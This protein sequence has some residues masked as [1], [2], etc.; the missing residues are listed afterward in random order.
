METIKEQ[1]YSGVFVL[2]GVNVPG[3]IIH[4]PSKGT[5]K[6][7][8]TRKLEDQETLFALSQVNYR[9]RESIKGKLHTGSPIVLFNCRN[10]TNTLDG[11]AFVH[12][13]RFSADY[14]IFDEI[15]HIGKRYCRYECIIENGLLW[16]DMTQLQTVTAD[17]ILTENHD[18]L[19]VRN[20]YIILFNKAAASKK[21]KWYD[22]EIEF[23]TYLD[24]ADF[25]RYP[26]GES[27]KVIERLKI[28]ITPQTRKNVGHFL[29]IRREI[30]AMI[31]FAI[32]DNVNILQ[33]H[34]YNWDEYHTIPIEDAPPIKEH[35][36]Y[37]MISNERYHTV[38][39]VVPQEY[40]FLLSQLPEGKNFDSNLEK[41][42]PVFHLYL[43]F[44]TYPDMPYEMLFLNMTQ[45]LETFHEQFYNKGISPDI[46]LRERLNELLFFKDTPFA[47]FRDND[48]PYAEILVKTR[49]YYTHYDPSLKNAALK[50][51]DL[52]DAIQVL[53]WLLEY[54]VCKTLRIDIS[55]EVKKKLDKYF[56]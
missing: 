49:N 54:Q 12:T 39:D 45:A 5:I 46:T 34:F 32:K 2:D 47:R 37:G 18:N 55:E 8:L 53:K 7:S 16:S 25:N 51:N 3:V 4:N 24:T 36:L 27:N 19:D 14:M 1:R 20:C 23:S 33:Q 48:P 26:V 22:A 35:I 30:L 17:N 52:F 15:N 6:L 11:N 28:T 10:L 40:N 50:R 42:E 21:F 38:R 44:Y 9:H 56:A 41:L 43:S 31:T 29:R 13:L